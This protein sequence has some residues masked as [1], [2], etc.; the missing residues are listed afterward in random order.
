MLRTSLRA[1]AALLALATLASLLLMHADARAQ[2]P[3]TYWLDGYEVE[4]KLTTERESFF[5]GEPVM[6]FLIFEGRS[7]T[8]LE[9]LLSGEKGGAGW[10]DDFEVT[11]TGPDGK[12]L[13]RPEDARAETSYTNTFMRGS[14]FAKPEMRIGV[15][16]KSW[17]NLETPGLYTVT[18]KRGVR[19]GPYN[20]RRY[21]IFPGTTR[22]A[23]EVRAETQ[24][25]IVRR[26]DD[27]LGGLVEELSQKALVC[28]QSD[29]VNATLRLAALEDERAVKQL[30]A[31]M[32][33]CKNASIKYTALAGLSKFRTDEAFEAL[34]A[35][36]SD[37]DEDFRTV[38][39]NELGRNKHP[40]AYAL[41]VSMRH[42]SYY[43]VRLMVLHALESKNT[44]TSRRL[45]WEM[46]NDEHPMVR[47]EALQFFQLRREPSGP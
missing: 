36:A 35:A 1:H 8:D 10:P 31:L 27:D 40:K 34:R 11:I 30:A 39:V 2:T 24:V 29:S 12:Q 45:A 15:S 20:G 14:T 47:N 32:S 17:A 5:V 44:E 6:L 43:G 41:V 38:V 26:G 19:A 37:P 16:L 22:P 42:D 4:V 25:R 21:R 7:D 18:V 13:A 28:D 23:V 46:T 9:L 3:E 33:K